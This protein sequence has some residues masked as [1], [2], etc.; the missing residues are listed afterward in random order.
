MESEIKSLEEHD[1][2]EW[3]DKPS[4]TQIQIIPSKFIFKWKFDKNRNP[5]RQKSRVV[6]QG[7]HENDSGADKAA[8]V[9][10]IESVRMVL[11]L[12][13]KEDMELILNFGHRLRLTV[14]LG[15]VLGER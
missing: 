13:A 4:D 8:P 6:V 7:F 11:A 3:V 12:T 10:H 9:A 1:V 15:Q 5:V 14:E 2:F